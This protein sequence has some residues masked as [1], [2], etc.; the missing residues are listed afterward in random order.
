[1]RIAKYLASCGLGSRRKSEELIKAGKVKINGQVDTDLSRQVDFSD[2]V[3]INNQKCEPKAKVYYLVNK[4][5]GVT[6]TVSDIHAKK[7]V[8]ELV[9]EEPPVWPIGRLDKETEGL[10]ILSNDGDLTQKLT[11]PSFG[12]KKEY[13][14]ILNRS[15]SEKELADIHKEIMLDDGPV[16][17]DRIEKLSDNKY[18]IVVHEGRN[19]LV[20]RIFGHFGKEVIGLERTKIGNLKLDNLKRGEYRQ[21]SAEEISE[22]LDA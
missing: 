20:R 22:L 16:K 21:L 1:M 19:R 9:P 6:S 5:K 13:I 2:L 15:L 8:I 17:P 3:E 4:P 10:I 18:R 7:T 11:H 12:K 14:A